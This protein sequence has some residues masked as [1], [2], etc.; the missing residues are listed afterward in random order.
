MKSIRAVLDNAFWGVIPSEDLE[1]KSPFWTMSDEEVM[2]WWGKIASG[3][4]LGVDIDWFAK[5]CIP[6]LKKYD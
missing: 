5:T 3:Y 4:D 6:V 2:V 1:G